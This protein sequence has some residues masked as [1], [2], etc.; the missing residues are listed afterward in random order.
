VGERLPWEVP[1]PAPPCFPP[2]VLVGHP[3][4]EVMGGSATYKGQPLF[5]LEPEERA[6]LGLFLRCAVLY[7]GVVWSGAVFLG[8]FLCCAVLWWVWFPRCA[9]LCCAV[10]WGSP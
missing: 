6:R 3:D 10:V 2:Q 8:L 1:H 4:Y 9:V 7:Y 5:D